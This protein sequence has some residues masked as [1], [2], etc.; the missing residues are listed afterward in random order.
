MEKVAILGSGNG[1]LAMA[2]HLSLKGFHVHLYDKF[3]E[4]IESIQQH[5]GVQVKG[6]LVHGYAPFHLISTDLG[7]T[8]KDCSLIIVV[9]PA[10]AHRDIAKGLVSC[11][12]PD[13][14]VVLHPGRTGGALETKHILQKHNVQA[15]VA[16]TQ[17]LL[18]ASRRTGPTEVTIYGIKKKVAI[19]AL[20]TAETVRVAERINRFLPYFEPV[21]SILYT[22]FHNIGAIFHPAP[23]ILNTGRI[24]TPNQP[25][26]YYHEGIT[27][28]VA[29]LLER[30]DE[31]RVLVAK[32][33]GVDVPRAKE[34][35]CESYGVDGETLWDAI[36]NNRTYR[37][38]FAPESVQVR[39]LSED[40][41]M[42]LVPISC[43]GRLAGVKTP[44]IDAIIELAS[45]IHGT[46]YRK[47]GR[48]LQAL[49]LDDSIDSLWAAVS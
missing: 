3:P 31:E 19:A 47:N 26:E 18:Y 9:T 2:G 17:T 42:S 8:I 33:Y 4:A 30:M 10:F 24:E 15:T 32:V 5:G 39:Y 7:E 37:G 22:S 25:F 48:N 34:W 11:L 36:Q 21:S 6:E 23:T 44:A 20:P 13:Q 45:I 28:S 12:K 1:G 35:L 49:G 38:I 29:K 46:D 14:M 27:P 16:E 41:P 40:V 43:L